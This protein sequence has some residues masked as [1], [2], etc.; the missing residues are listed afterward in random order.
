MD[1]SR[2]VSGCAHKGASLISSAGEFQSETLELLVR[3]PI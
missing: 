2:I 1:C 3:I